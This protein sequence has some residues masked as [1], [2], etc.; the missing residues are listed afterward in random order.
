MRAAHQ[1]TIQALKVSPDA[2][3]PI[4]NIALLL[5]HLSAMPAAVWQLHAP[6]LWAVDAGAVG[7]LWLLAPRGVPARALG[8]AWLLPLFLI[9]PLLPPPVV[10][11]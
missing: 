9:V 1:G 4:W 10:G 8:L 6:R 7:V 3:A 2:L 5:E 11:G